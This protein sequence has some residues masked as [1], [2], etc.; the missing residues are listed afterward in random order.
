MG[1][2]NKEM[3]HLCSVDLSN[4]KIHGSTIKIICYYNYR[5]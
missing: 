1:K 5:A 3:M 4:V 2:F